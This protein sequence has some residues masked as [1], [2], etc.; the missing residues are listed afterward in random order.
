MSASLVG[1]E[2][3]IRDRFKTPWSASKS[4]GETG[5]PVQ[6]GAVYEASADSNSPVSYT[7]LTLPTI[8]SV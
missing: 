3:C 7:H 8:C 4:L 2:M 1:S 5:Y 6:R